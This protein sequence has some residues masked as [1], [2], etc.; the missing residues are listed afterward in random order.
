MDIIICENIKTFNHF[1]F[2][3]EPTSITE[4]LETAK[5]WS[6]NSTLPPLLTLQSMQYHNAEMHG[7][8]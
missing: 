7:I 4:E 1:L 5:K 8:A 3:L 6:N 2:S